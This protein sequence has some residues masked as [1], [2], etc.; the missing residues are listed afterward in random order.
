MK[1]ELNVDMTRGITRWFA[2]RKNTSR[3][4]PGRSARI[5][6]PPRG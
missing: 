3:R 4:E 6:P 2:Q 1:D 5:P